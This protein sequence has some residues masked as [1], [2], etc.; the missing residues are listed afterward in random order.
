MATPEDLARLIAEFGK[1]YGKWIWAE[2]ERAGTT[3]ARARLLL[4]LQCGAERTMS[5]VSEL[6]GVTPRSVTK[7]VDGLEAEGL[8]R[9]DP[10]P[11]D[12]RATLLRLTE[13]GIAVAKESGLVN[14]AAVT[15]LYARLSP[16][17]RA[18]LARIVRQLLEAV[19]TSSARTDPGSGPVEPP[20]DA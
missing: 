2:T 15:G 12:R 9:R 11:T 13:R 17:D 6:L 7:L 5:D 8:V 19:Q 16:A 14:H 20:A 3:P 18:D 10:H 4:A 1:A